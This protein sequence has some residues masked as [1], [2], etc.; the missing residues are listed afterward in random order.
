MSTT[1]EQVRKCCVEE[2]VNKEQLQQENKYSSSM[3]TSYCTG[4][5]G[6]QGLVKQ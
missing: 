5:I 2:V 4:P 6:K 1:V 3:Q